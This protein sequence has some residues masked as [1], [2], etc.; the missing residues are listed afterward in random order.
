ML[1][2]LFRNLISGEKYFVIMLSNE[3]SF[4]SDQVDCDNTGLNKE[5]S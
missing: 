4:D 5:V 2:E 1:W 3:K